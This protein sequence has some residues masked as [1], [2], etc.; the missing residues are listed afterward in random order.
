MMNQET[1]DNLFRLELG[2]GM[3]PH[4]RIDA[5]PDGLYIMELGDGGDFSQTKFEGDE[6]QARAA[7]WSIYIRRVLGEMPPG[8]T[9]QVG[10]NGQHQWMRPE[11]NE[12]G[13]PMDSREEAVEMS[14]V[15]YKAIRLEGKRPPHRKDENDPTM[16]MVRIQGLTFRRVEM[17]DARKKIVAQLE[18]LDNEMARLT[19]QYGKVVMEARRRGE[20]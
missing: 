15:D 14:W 2:G 7:A 11:Q 13:M 8:Y 3:P 10:L 17:N 5:R 9:V 6:K 1:I 18:Q 16:L 4:F 12:V 20:I 19:A